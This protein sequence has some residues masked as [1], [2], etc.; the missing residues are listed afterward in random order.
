MEQNTPCKT[1]SILL[2]TEEKKYVLLK[3]FATYQYAGKKTKIE[4]FPLLPKPNHTYQNL[5][6]TVEQ[7]TTKV[8]Y[9]S[10]GNP[11]SCY[12]TGML[13]SK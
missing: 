13:N 4:P 5:E 11:K 1:M 7:Q 9:L 10:S 2:S 6:R 8:L 3:T 12:V